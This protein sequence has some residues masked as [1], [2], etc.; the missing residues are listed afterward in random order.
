MLRR[1][2]ARQPNPPGPERVGKSVPVEVTVSLK[3]NLPSI[4][5]VFVMDTS[6][7]NGYSGLQKCKAMM[8]EILKSLP[9]V[10]FVN[11]L[12]TRVAAIKYYT[13][14]YTMF[15]FAR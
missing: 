2:E 12:S 8:I 6:R 3:C 10:S 4:D 9:A 5:V 15:N 7:R 13:R 1:A 11:G 14:S